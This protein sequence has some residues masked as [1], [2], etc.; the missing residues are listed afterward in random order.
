MEEKRE[1]NIFECTHMQKIKAYFY[2]IFGILRLRKKPTGIFF[3]NTRNKESA[4][5]IFT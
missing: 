2:N 4:C 5:L 1:I 3:I